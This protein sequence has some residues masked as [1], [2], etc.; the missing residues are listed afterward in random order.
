[1]GRPAT[2]KPKRGEPIHLSITVDGGLILDLDAEAERMTTETPGMK[3]NRT[4]MVRI[5]LHEWLA[6]RAKGRAEKRGK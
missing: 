1:M 5:G 3:Y 4:D 2:R 6:W